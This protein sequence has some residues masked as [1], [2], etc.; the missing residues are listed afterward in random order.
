MSQNPP[1]N[2]PEGAS[3]GLF[4]IRDWATKEQVKSFSRWL[5]NPAKSDEGKMHLMRSEVMREVARKITRE[6]RK[7]N[8]KLIRQA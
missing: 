6:L 1:K 8:S 5:K 3:H 7:Q 2:A 4:C